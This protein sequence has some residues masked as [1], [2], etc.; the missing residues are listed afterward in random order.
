MTLP[1]AAYQFEDGPEIISAPP[2]F[3][4]HSEEILSSLGYSDEEIEQLRE[5][6]VIA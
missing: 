3:S 1:S 5:E 6:G 4:E 2:G